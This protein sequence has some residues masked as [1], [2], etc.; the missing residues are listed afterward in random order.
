MG[1]AMLIGV[2]AV[3]NRENVL[4]RKIVHK[5]QVGL[6]TGRAKFERMNSAGWGLRFP[7]LLEI[8]RNYH[9]AQLRCVGCCDGIG[10][11]GLLLSSVP[12]SVRSQCSQLLCACL[13]RS[14]SGPP[15]QDVFRGEVAVVSFPQLST[16][17]DFVVEL[18]KLVLWIVAQFEFLEHQS[19]N[20]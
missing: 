20:R 16:V 17:G 9:E 11:D 14:G 19:R 3:G 12:A 2:E 4:G 5:L 10:L 1:L 6:D 15:G 8:R 7:A 18:G 13:F